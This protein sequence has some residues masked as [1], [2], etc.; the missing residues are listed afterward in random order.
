MRLRAYSILGRRLCSHGL[1]RC[2]DGNRGQR[3][4]TQLAQPDTPSSDRQR[5]SPAGFPGDAPA[6]GSG[7]WRCLSAFGVIA[8]RVRV[9]IVD[10]DDDTD[11]GWL[12]DPDG[13]SWL[14]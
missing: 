4:P 9:G 2:L 8:Y 5:H 12:A 11:N 7:R 6:I 13:V 10:S 3:R 14:R 1:H